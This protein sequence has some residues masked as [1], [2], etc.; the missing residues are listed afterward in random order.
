MVV[1]RICLLI[2]IFAVA[3]FFCGRLLTDR[4][5]GIGLAIIT[6]MVMM[7]ATFMPICLFMIYRRKWLSDVIKI[8]LPVLAVM[9]LA[10]ILVTFVKKLGITKRV[11][12]GAAKADK[13]EKGG[14]AKADKREKAGAAKADK[15]EKGGAATKFDKAAKTGDAV[16]IGRNFLSKEEIIYLSIAL[17]LMIFMLYKS[18][19][20]SVFDGDDAYYVSEANIINQ[21]EWLY[22]LDPYT[23]TGIGIMWRYACAPFPAFVAML[24]RLSGLHAATVSHIV[25]PLIMIP[26]SFIVWNEFGKKLFEKDKLRKYMFLDLMA[27]IAL[28]GRYSISTAETFMLSRSRQGKEALAAFVIPFMLVTLAKVYEKSHAALRDFFVLL[29]IVLSAAICSVFGNVCA[30]IVLFGWFI[31]CVVKKRPLTDLMCSAALALP[32]LAMIFIYLKLG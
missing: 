16:T 6:G 9:V 22:L 25:M 10:G 24:A 27:V 26:A 30:L 8:Y 14:A 23:G 2:L 21:A 18:V 32:G 15:R 13:R 12:V 5:G 19:T 20:L 4:K 11:K 29:A 3:A 31:A 7:W 17:G 28:F 1:V